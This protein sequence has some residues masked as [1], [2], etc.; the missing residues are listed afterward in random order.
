MGALVAFELVRALRR[1]GHPQPAA[2]VVSAMQAP[3]KVEMAAY[4]R[5]LTETRI[6]ELA[7]GGSR[8]SSIDE[9]RQLTLPTLRADA[10]LL[11]AYSYRN[12]PSL[13]VPIIVLGGQQD[14]IVEPD[15][16][17]HWREEAGLSFDMTI[18]PGDH[19]YLFDQPNGVLKALRRALALAAM[20]VRTGR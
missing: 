4:V 14:T 15:E 10:H 16:L 13:S 17:G 20:E 12:E 11:R 9:L 19:F 1:G 8:H 18:F 6:A 3:S 7:N 5:S 2:L